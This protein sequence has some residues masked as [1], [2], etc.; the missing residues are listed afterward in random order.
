MHIYIGFC[1]CSIRWNLFRNIWYP[2]EV[3]VPV[4]EKW[5]AI[6]YY[7]YLRDIWS[8]VLK[9][10]GRKWNTCKRSIGTMCL[11]SSVRYP[12]KECAYPTIWR[13]QNICKSKLSSR[14]LRGS[15]FSK[16]PQNVN[17]S[18][19]PDVCS[20]YLGNK[21]TLK[22]ETSGLLTTAQLK[23]EGWGG[24]ATGPPALLPDAHLEDM[25]EIAQ[26]TRP[27]TPHLV[28]GSSK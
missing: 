27:R 15:S 22:P 1:V 21:L 2:R 6:Q 17:R 8:R 10:R 20:L 7:G 25:I 16:N 23:H 14:T 24:L 19:P 5:W 28:S 13:P 11:L 12:P 9:L 18:I 4:Y 26:S 3:S